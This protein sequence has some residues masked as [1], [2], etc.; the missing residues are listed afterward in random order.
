MKTKNKISLLVY[1]ILFFSLNIKNLH[2]E[3]PVYDLKALKLSY[4]DNNLIIA[5][6]LASAQDQFGRKIFA[7]FMIY[8][9]LNNTITTKSNSKYTDSKG[10][11]IL[12]DIFLYDLN[13]NKITA[14]KNVE[15]FDK[16]KNK[17]FFTQLEYYENSEIGYGKN[18]QS[19]QIDGSSME[20]PFVVINNNTGV[21]IL[22]ATSDNYRLTN[23]N[24]NRYTTCKKENDTSKNIKDR[25]PD[26]SISTSKTIHDAKTKMIYHKDAFINIRNFPVFYTPYFSHPDPSV[27]RKSGFLAPST[28]NFS[29]LGRTI[30]SPYFW[31]IDEKSDLTFTPIFYQDENSIFLSEY[32][33]QNKNGNLILDTSYSQGY[34]DL[35]KR[36][37][38]G[39][40]LQ[41]TGG[42]RNH[43]F[44]KFLGS[45]NDLI[46]RDN[47]IEL[48]I[49][50]IS[51]K[52]YLT[53]NQINTDYVKQDI[54]S[55]NNSFIISSYEKNKKIKISSTI[56][57]N[58][59]NDDKNTKYQYTVPSIEYNNFFEKF[60]QNFNFNN[61]FSAKNYGGDSKQINQ[62]NIIET[63]SKP[64]ILKKIGISNTFKTK[65]SNIN[66]YNDQVL[67]NKENFN[68]NFY[69]T[70]ALESSIPLARF[71]DKTEEIINPKIFMKYSPGKMKN[72]QSQ[73]KI[74]S[75]SD[76][77]SMDRMNSLTNPETGLSAGYGLEY[78]IN[79]KKLE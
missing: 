19:K 42:S 38:N 21:T 1:I 71:L 41:R 79:K 27:D 72:E 34:K 66:L 67:N 20:G 43:L 53:V 8:D 31:A 54:Q 74:L 12:A 29:N 6:G 22:S 73:I 58:L 76:I 23:D 33:M 10:N 13:Q 44:A 69:N 55:L 32:R 5:E 62:T 60:N 30:K 39:E 65:F 45:F 61:S 15:Y 28:K 48:N 64:I 11:R 3:I 75:Y 59:N 36:G 25:C 37:E 68:N 24:K 14:K 16:N 47:D 57:E 49:Q 35:N 18:F 50:R 52:N 2:S 63:E 46:L 77:Y 9:K 56:Y 78:E 4:K 17:F 40:D 7:D 51:Q 26:W 70:V